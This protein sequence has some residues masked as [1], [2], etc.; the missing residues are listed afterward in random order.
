MNNIVSQRFIK[1]HD[2][3]R[4]ENRIRSSRQFAMALDFLPQSLS[5]ILKGRRDVTVELLRRAIDTFGLNPHYLYTGEGPMFM[6]VEEKPHVKVLTVIKSAQGEER[7]VHVPAPAQALYAQETGNPGFIEHLPTFTLP[8]YQYK[9]GTFRSFEVVGDNMHPTL[10]EGDRVVCSFLESALW[11]SAIKD[12]YM[13]VIVTPGDILIR[14]ALNFL[15]E[16]R[17]LRLLSD[18]PSYGP[19]DIGLHEIQEI[20]YARSRF[21]ASLKHPGLAPGSAGA[22]IADTLSL[23][24]EQHQLILS[25]LQKMEQF[26]G[27]KP[28]KHETAHD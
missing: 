4:E 21:C 10:C 6:S 27:Q 14:R 3:L 8:D 24:R 15:R 13:Y 23:L 19:M 1:C 2:K 16:R 9:S 18:N 11:E 22:G 5:E 26:S 25:L 17:H 20:W 12:H 28:N 7:I